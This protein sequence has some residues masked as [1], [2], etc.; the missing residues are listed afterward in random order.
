[1]GYTIKNTRHLKNIL[2]ADFIL[3]GLTAFTGLVFFRPLEGFLGLSQPFI[4]LVS[5]ANILYA[6]AAFTLA[7][8]Q[9]N[10]SIPL[11]RLLIGANWFWTLLSVALLYI[12]YTSVTTF[13]LTTLLF[14]IVI[15]GTLAYL[16]GNQLEKMA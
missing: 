5:L 8:T 16:E 4:I 7:T 3:G 13:G 2:R 14:Q 9:R 10:P 15:V 6:T 1:M 11:L 12:H